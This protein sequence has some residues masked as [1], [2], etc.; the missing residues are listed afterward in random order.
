MDKVLRKQNIFSKN[1]RLKHFNSRLLCSSFCV[2]VV[3]S[4]H[5]F[6]E[7]PLSQ[8]QLEAGRTGDRHSNPEG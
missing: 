3:F 2:F 6:G 1:S 4:A 7:M 8:R 5:R